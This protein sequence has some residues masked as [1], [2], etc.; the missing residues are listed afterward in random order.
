[1]KK[2]DQVIA[3]LE[4]LKAEATQREAQTSHA[5]NLRKKL[6]EQGAL[7]LKAYKDL[8]KQMNRQNGTDSKSPISTKHLNKV[9]MEAVYEYQQ[10]VNVLIQLKGM[11][12]EAR[13]QMFDFTQA[14]EELKTNDPI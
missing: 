13:N 6:V 7:L 3:R 5:I 10:H 9:R 14:L 11:N 4:D 12:A 8:I 2:L 1:M